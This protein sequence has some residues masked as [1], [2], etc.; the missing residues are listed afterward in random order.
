MKIFSWDKYTS[1]KLATQPHALHTDLQKE[2]VQRALWLNP[3]ITKVLLIGDYWSP[4]YLPTHTD[5]HVLSY[6]KTPTNQP[7]ALKSFQDLDHSAYSHILDLNTFSFYEDIPNTLKT[8]YEKLAPKG[9]FLS[10]LVGE[11]SLTELKNAFLDADITLKG[12]ASGRIAPMIT[13]QD[14]ALL[15]QK[16]GFK[17][18]TSDIDHL[19][20]STKDSLSL[21]KLLKKYGYTNILDQTS[22]YMGKKYFTLIDAFYHAAGKITEGNLQTTLDI[23]YVG[24]I[25]DQKK[26]R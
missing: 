12:G 11:Y 8:A 25:K 6:R 22:D 26:I 3:H 24:G 20:L 21:L 9:V 19:T 14:S 1:R 17:N 4:Q 16:A 2:L 13:L 18:C 23:I 10:A 7:P 5:F 15:L